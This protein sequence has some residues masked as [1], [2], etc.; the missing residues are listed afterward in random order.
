SLAQRRCG[1]LPQSSCSS[2][3]TGGKDCSCWVGGQRWSGKSTVWCGLTSSADEQTYTP[4]SSF[5]PFSAACGVSVGWCCSSGRQF[6]WLRSWCWKCCGRKTWRD[7]RR[8]RR[9]EKPHC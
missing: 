6:S 1:G 3:D 9:E 4:C 8:E 5:L 2:Q 7:R